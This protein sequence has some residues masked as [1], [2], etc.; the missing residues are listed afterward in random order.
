MPKK[1]PLL[2]TYLNH[3]KAWDTCTECNIGK[4]SNSRIYYRGTIPAD[5]L[6]VGESPNDTDLVL[7]KPF[8]GPAGKCLDRLLKDAYSD[9]DEEITICMTYSILCAPCQ[10]PQFKLRAPS[11]TEIRNCSKRLQQFYD[12][13][14]PKHVVCV[15][16]IA[17][18][19]VKKLR[20]YKQ[21]DPPKYTLIPSPTS[22]INQEEQGTLDYK[23]AFCALKEINI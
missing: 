18:K 16:R 11:E 17:E 6:I 3:K 2:P 4:L 13:V 20:G 9:R 5:I 23:R 1:T 12:M 19:A 21:A 8:S 15:G 10:P 14:K 7:N 22:I